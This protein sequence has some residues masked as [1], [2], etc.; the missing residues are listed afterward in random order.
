MKRKPWGDRR[1]APPRIGLFEHEEKTLVGPEALRIP[2][3]PYHS[4]SR[5]ASIGLAYKYP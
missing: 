1:A 5:P 4:T 2:Y 3:R